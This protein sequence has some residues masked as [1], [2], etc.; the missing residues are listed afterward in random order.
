MMSR[1]PICAAIACRLGLVL[2]LAWP[3]MAGAATDDD[4]SDNDPRTSVPVDAIADAPL[5]KPA[6]A[7]A[8]GVAL[9]SSPEYSGSDRQ[10]LS[11]KP[12]FAL[13]YKRIKFSSSGGSSILNFGRTADDSGA[14]AQIIDYDRWKLRTSLRIGGGRDSDD[15]VDLDGLPD[16]RKTVIARLAGSYRISDHWSVDASVGWDLLGHGNGAFLAGGVGYRWR[17]SPRSELG[18]GTGITWG[19]RSHMFAL[20]G[21]PAYAATESRPRYDAGPSLKDVSTGMGIIT[22][23]SHQW[24]MFGGIGMSRLLGDAAESPLTKGRSSV[25]ANFGIGWRC[26]D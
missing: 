21:V 25:S 10:A 8:I 12:L 5:P 3:G 14:T 19:S 11:L 16:L 20:Y 13:R 15:S 7:L 24:I 6:W 26:C 4:T 9:N 1:T 17:L 22:Q 18:I 23:L 2:M